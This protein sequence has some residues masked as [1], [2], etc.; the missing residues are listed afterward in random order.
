MLSNSP[1]GIAEFL[2]SADFHAL[3]VDHTLECRD[4][5][6]CCHGERKDREDK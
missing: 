5:D 6:H 4:D 2:E 3:F 1:I